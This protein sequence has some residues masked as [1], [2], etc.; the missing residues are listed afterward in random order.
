MRKVP[1][2]AITH[3]GRF[4]ADDVFSAA[5]LKIMNP[6]IEI[7]RI[8][9]VPK[10]Y[11]G[12]VFDLSDGEF[13]HHGEKTKYR[14]NGVP[15]ASFGLLWNEYGP[16]LVGENAARTFDEIFVQPLDIQDNNGGNNMLARA[17]TQA[18]PKWDS[19]DNPNECFEKVVEFAKF[20]LENEIQSMHSTS[21]AVGIVKKALAEQ[22]DGIVVLPVGVPWKS[23]LIPEPVMYVVYPST[24]GGYNAQ[25]VPKAIDTQECKKLFPEIWRGKREGLGQ[26]TGL[27]QIIFCHPGG[28]LINANTL[29]EAVMACKL[30]IKYKV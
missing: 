11:D 2:E 16:E 9:S 22:K 8:K 3:M 19:T 21:K 12:L 27:K 7:I 10:G 15:Y 23:I 28:Y 26:I 29:E 17:I 30:S 18:N 24:R 14:E 25:A 4:H 6:E 13:D 1:N 5:L 20:I